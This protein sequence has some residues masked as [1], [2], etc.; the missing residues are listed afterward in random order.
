MDYGLRKAFDEEEG[1]KADIEDEAIALDAAE[2]IADIFNEGKT[3]K[4]ISKYFKYSSQ[5]KSK[6]KIN[7]ELNKE[8]ME[9]KKNQLLSDA[10]TQTKVKKDI[11][12]SISTYEQEVTVKNFLN[13][14]KD[15]DFMGNN[16]RG[17][18][19]FKKGKNLVEIT[20]YGTKA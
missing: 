16:T 3:H 17:S 14:N 5:E 7:R 8:L 12:N 10:I 2:A 1:L 9:E 15:F 19:V 18:L 4:T 13:E 20:K 6:I 11:L